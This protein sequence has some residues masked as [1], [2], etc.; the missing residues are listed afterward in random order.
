MDQIKIDTNSL[1]KRSKS[2]MFTIIILSV[3]LIIAIGAAVYFGIK[4]SGLKKTDSQ[5]S[6]QL[7]TLQQDPAIRL[8]EENQ[9][10]LTAVGKLINLPADEQPTI[11]TV[12][13]LT[14]LQGQPFFQ[15]AQIG[16]KVLIYENAKKAILY[17]PSTNKIIEVAP[18]ST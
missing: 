13:D 9:Q 11:A 15:D 1:T 3:L 5:L 10:I 6:A 16:D 8:K 12:T 7:N 18:L 17:R 4:F 14:K 2:S